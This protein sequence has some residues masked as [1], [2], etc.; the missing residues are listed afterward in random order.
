VGTRNPQNEFGVGSN[1]KILQ[2]QK[3]AAFMDWHVVN[4]ER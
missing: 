2:M 3:R 4:Q 1:L